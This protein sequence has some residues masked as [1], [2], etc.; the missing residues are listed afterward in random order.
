MVKISILEDRIYV[1]E[2]IQASVN[3]EILDKT[4]SQVCVG[5][6][7]RRLKAK[8]KF[9]WPFVWRRTTTA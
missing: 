9:H 7:R 4:R 3:H 2:T 5:T 1:L 6:L 8:T